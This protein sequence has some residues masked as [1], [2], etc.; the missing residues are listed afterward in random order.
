MRYYSANSAQYFLSAFDWSFAQESILC[1]R[2]INFIIKLRNENIDELPVFVRNN[3][4]STGIWRNSSFF[5]DLRNLQNNLKNLK[6]GHTNFFISPVS[7]SLIMFLLESDEF[8]TLTIK[9]EE[10][11]R[12]KQIDHNYDLIQLIYTKRRCL[13]LLKHF[14]PIQTR[15]WQI[16]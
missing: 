15:I 1:L 13:L 16:F 10:F 11:S 2:L 9:E 6:I 12:F 4:F 7:S 5:E 8:L 14:Q 3:V